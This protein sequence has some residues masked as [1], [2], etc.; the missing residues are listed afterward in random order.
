MKDTIKILFVGTP[1]AY[2]MGY[3][4]ELKDMGYNVTYLVD[5]PKDDTLSRPEH[6]YS[7]ISYPYPKW[8]IEKLIPKPHW[9]SFYPKV[10]HGDLIRLCN[11]YDVVLL[12]GHYVSIAPY[13]KV[14]MVFG[15]YAGADLYFQSNP[16]RASDWVNQGMKLPLLNSLKLIFARRC[17]QNNK[18]GI[19]SLN[20]IVYFP[21]GLVRESKA[22]I[23]YAISNGVNY[24]KR[25]DVNPRIL[26][27]ER[28]KVERDSKF[29]INS[30]VRFCFGNAPGGD[31]TLNKGNDVIIR[32]IALFKKHFEDF[33]VHFYNK[34]PDLELAKSLCRELDIEENVIWHNTMP[35]PDLLSIYDISDVCF[36]QVGSHWVSAVGCYSLFLGVPLIANAR[37]EIMGDFWEG[38]SPICQA[39]TDEEI[40]SWLIKLLDEKN[41]KEIGRRSKIF[42]NK[43]LS[44]RKV[45][46]EID[47]MIGV[48]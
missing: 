26:H 38:E 5:V 43:K 6:Q 17:M 28:A 48:K 27:C 18:F 35:L 47:E 37:P 45:A 32:G 4:L 13:I 12:S 40:C 10:L 36:D 42:A 16:D 7:E 30:P 2:P 22:M 34:G 29:V 9:K 1:N 21:V 14:N 39:T 33:E 44:M 25:Y 3:A 24:I 19:L 46:L 8:I 41:R 20:S 11:E 23:N 31:V 15:L